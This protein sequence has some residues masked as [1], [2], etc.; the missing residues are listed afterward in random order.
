MHPPPPI[1][2]LVTALQSSKEIFYSLLSQ[3]IQKEKAISGM[4]NILL[5]NAYYGQWNSLTVCVTSKLKDFNLYLEIYC[6]IY[7]FAYDIS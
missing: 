6:I 4:Q 1:N 7:E 2:A 3:I 5:E